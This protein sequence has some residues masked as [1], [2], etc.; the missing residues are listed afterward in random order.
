VTATASPRP[1]AQPAGGPPFAVGAVVSARSWR[2][3]LQRHCR[4][5]VVDTVVR[6]V[7]DARDA[8]EEPVE[9]LLLDDDTS[10]LSAPLVLR[11]RE[12]G[13]V[14]VGLYDP[15]ESDGHGY[16]FLLSVGVDLAL[17]ATMPPD[18][19]LEA[20]TELRPDQ[21]AADR[22]ASLTASLED[23]RPVGVRRVVAVGG[24]AGSGATEVS[25]A[26]AQALAARS[27]VVLI[28][29]DEVQPSIARRLGLSLHPHVVTAIETL[30]RERVDLRGSD[31]S[32][33]VDCLATPAIGDR[34]PFDVISGL[35]TGQDWGL[36]RADDA[37]DLIDEASARWEVVVARIGPRLEDLGRWIGRY[38]VSR[39]CLEAA[40]AAVAV[41]EA[42]PVGVLR[43]LDWLG[44]AV[45]L[46]PDGAV[47]AVLNQAPRSP[48]QRAQLLDQLSA[49][50]GARVRSVTVAPSDRR[51]RRAAWDAA[52]VGEG[53]FRRSLSLLAG[54]LQEP[55]R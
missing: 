22:F 15:D 17:P 3:A 20:V 52:L 55:V 5:H 21:G 41:C 28:D 44:D 14:T 24:P 16:R 23:R 18:E 1:R 7:R 33:L 51:V 42:S 50:A 19:L 48:G 46:V 6:V 54:R 45:D 27:S 43:F 32:T 4:D 35:A 38:D 30:R 25:I 37:V 2:G 36:L 40:T 10:Y 49:V 39:R 53:P 34:L 47:D 12:H 8:L 11:L 13:V 31:A 26:V 29:L 9:V